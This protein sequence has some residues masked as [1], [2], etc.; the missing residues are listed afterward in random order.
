MKNKIIPIVV[1]I[2]V[3]VGIWFHYHDTPQ[4]TGLTL[5][6]NVDIRQ[7]DMTFN[8]SGRIDR[9]LVREGDRVKAGQLLASLDT[10]RLQLSLA[11]IEAQTAAQRDVLARYLAGSRP[12]EIR[13]ARAQLD[14]ARATAADADGYYRRQMDLVSRHFVSRQQADSA[15]FARDKAQAQLNAA[16]ETLHLAELGPRREDIATAR[17][18]RRSVD[19]GDAARHSGRPVACAL[20]RRD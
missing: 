6:G 4:Q 14:A 19:R 18:N 15:K 2:A 13:Q 20:G 17:A 10:G 8:A 7:V 12:E 9:I 3:A 1:I 5:H 11:Q 16:E